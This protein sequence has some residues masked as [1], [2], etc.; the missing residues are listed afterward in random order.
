MLVTQITTTKNSH[1][2]KFS[3]DFIFDNPYG[4]RREKIIFWCKW[5]Y[6][7]LTNPYQAWRFGFTTRKRIWFEIPIEHSEPQNVSDAFYLI[8]LPMAIATNED[9][10]FK[11]KVNPEI[12][13]KTREIEKYY[14]EISK[15]KLKIL[16]KVQKRSVKNYTDYE[17][18]AQFFT[19][20]VDS[21]Y[22]LLCHKS[23]E[24]VT[25]LI[26]I[27]G[28]DI[29]FYQKDFLNNVHQKI[30]NVSKETK[31]IPIFASTNLRLTSDSVIGW[32]RFHVSALVAVHH[33]LK[34]NLIFISG[35]SFEAADWGLRFGV[36]KLYSTKNKPV[37]LVAHNLSREKKLSQTIKTN[38]KQLFLDNVRVCWE[39]VRS[40]E[41]IYNCSK[42]QKCLKTKLNLT[43]LN[44]DETPTFLPVQTADL[45]KIRLV[46]HVYEEWQHLYKSLK[47]MKKVDLDILS[48]IKK[49]LEKPLRV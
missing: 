46:G 31:T 16:T 32:G 38:H 18:V 8:A 28:Y 1:S 24:K 11:G 10:V 39:N 17:G 41:L 26:Y 19:L 6:K 45:E 12:L 48:A 9:L 44:I 5:F 4:G 2:Y 30:T 21:F 36:D 34:T 15:R 3:A 43:A 33:L 13:K 37:E 49:V 23:S 42:C 40:K 14:H 7:A 20:G 47:N 25:R 22:T 27:D 35:E 29:P